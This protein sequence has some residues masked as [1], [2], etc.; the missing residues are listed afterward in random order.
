MQLFDHA[1]IDARRQGLIEKLRAF[2]AARTVAPA[3]QVLEL[4]LPDGKKAPGSPEGVYGANRGAG[5]IASHNPDRSFFRYR[6]IYLPTVLAHSHNAQDLHA[7]AR[8]QCFFECM[9]I[10]HEF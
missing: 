10:F 8:S 5:V 7:A 4:D 9:V 2:V 6:G 3:R 1:E